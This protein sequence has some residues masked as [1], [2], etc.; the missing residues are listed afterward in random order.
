MPAGTKT[1]YRR[2]LNDFFKED[3]S[4]VPSSASA[5]TLGVGLT[6]V[7]GPPPQGKRSKS[8]AN[9]QAQQPM[10]DLH[11]REEAG[12]A[13]LEP[14]QNIDKERGSS[15]SGGSFVSQKRKRA[16]GKDEDSTALPEKKP[17]L[18]LIVGHK[19]ELR[20]L[21]L[22]TVPTAST[23]ATIQP[24]IP[25]PQAAQDLTPQDNALP[26][27]IAAPEAPGS[28]A[29]DS[30]SSEH[31]RHGRS[32]RGAVSPDSDTARSLQ[33]AIPLALLD[34]EQQAVKQ[35]K[36]KLEAA[37]GVPAPGL[38]KKKLLKIQKKFHEQKSDLGPVSLLDLMEVE[39]KGAYPDFAA[40]LAEFEK[41]PNGST[42]N[43][44]PVKKP[45]EWSRTDRELRNNL[46]SLFP[47]ERRQPG[48]LSR[49][50]DAVKAGHIVSTKELKLQSRKRKSTRERDLNWE[51]ESL[52]NQ[53]ILAALAYI[54]NLQETIEQLVRAHESELTAATHEQVARLQ[55]L[56][57]GEALKAK[58]EEF[59]K[60]LE[61]KN[62]E[63]AQVKKQVSLCV[64]AA[65]AEREEL[66]GMRDEVSDDRLQLAEDREKLEEEKVAFEE[67]K[68]N[69]EE[70]KRGSKKN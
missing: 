52:D 44:K 56:P 19:S 39:L 66:E 54:A 59:S 69:F 24:P 48:F 55:S 9:G 49:A 26:G 46:R 22:E 53:L 12:L 35:N 18:K 15:T 17:K 28:D 5:T 14:P 11:D 1:R 37:G 33:D 63:I 50:K 32:P 2:L 41:V 40:P 43:P 34:Q 64:L 65:R 51:D 23:T 3:Q 27:T 45:L 7:P 10:Q 42:V 57:D 61:A 60:T 58:H 16:V 29:S 68:R 38:T 25:L 13:S 20:R 67:E 8:G 21:E 31:S 47:P 70:S 36:A 30:G 62:A 6:R 4:T